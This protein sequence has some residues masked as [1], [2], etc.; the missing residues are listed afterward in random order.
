[1]QRAPGAE[2]ASGVRWAGN[3]RHWRSDSCWQSLSIQCPGTFV[4]HAAGLSSSTVS[5]SLATAPPLRSVRM[6][7]GCVLL[8]VRRP[9]VASRGLL[10]SCSFVPYGPLWESVAAV[11]N[12]SRQGVPACGSGTKPQGAVWKACSCSNGEG[13]MPTFTSRVMCAPTSRTHYYSRRAFRARAPATQQQHWG[14]RG[15]RTFR[16]FGTDPEHIYVFLSEKK[17]YFL[18]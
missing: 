2:T 10:F 9:V 15:V 16:K 6:M 8:H 14:W 7:S 18:S 13:Y 1:M 5:V 4:V 3:T 12:F 11:F 17:I